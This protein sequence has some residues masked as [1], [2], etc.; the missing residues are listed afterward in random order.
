MKYVSG[1][2]L[3]FFFL[4]LFP[5]GC[6]DRQMHGLLNDIETYIQEKPD[7]ALIVL[8]SVDKAELNT[9]SLRAHFALLYAMALDK[10]WIDTTDLDVVMPAIAYYNDHPSGD[11]R[12]KAWYYLGRIQ[13]NRGQN[14]EASISFLKAEIF[15]EPSKDYSLKALIYQA[16][17]NMYNKT[18]Y[19]EEAL[20][21]TELAYS[22]ALKAGDS[23]K[24]D[25]ARY[26][27][28]QDLHNVGRHV[29][30]DSLYQQLINENR[31]HRNLRAS[32]LCN[33]ALNQVTRNENYEQAC[34]L[35][36]E[37]ISSTGSLR[38]ENFWGAYAY[39]LTRQG[40]TVRAETIFQQLGAVK[41]NSS[42]M[43]VYDYWKGQAAA[44]LGD[45]R[46]AYPLQKAAAD[47]QN[48]NVKKL[49][50]QSAMKA[51]KD[52]LEQEYRESEKSA[53]KKQLLA[54]CSVGIILMILILLWVLYKRQK[55][56]SAKE[57]ESLME[58][59]KGLTLQH[60]ILSSQYLD[61]NAQV[62]R[63]EQEKVSVR[64]K[65]IQMCQS[66]FSRLGRINE[67][68]YYHSKESDSKLYH[69]IKRAIQNI[70]MDNKNQIEFEKLLNETFDEVMAHFRETFPNKKPRYY[71]LVSF[72]FAGFDSSTI[73]SIIPGFQKHNVHVEK[74]R[75][76]QTVRNTESPYRQQFL[77]L[78]S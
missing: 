2:H 64:N 14:P 58:A 71:Q 17:S 35:F 50:K 78:L 18:Y 19:N 22:F 69:E 68:L 52:Y 34:S 67:V 8:S 13:E 60:A 1:L 27:M 12:A 25:A 21:Y 44:Y 65:Y 10:N 48:D 57:K 47:I 53:K 30:S 23:L 75:L 49:L 38:N 32:L 9:K 42:Q 16:I 45:Y 39:A 72:L 3:F 29:E 74:F 31:L 24:I 5:V 33:Y 63:I 28:A 59:Y 43:Y 54:W 15:A 20:R 40:N 61:L 46:A 56:N 41:M 7:S 11:R 36:E 6:S 51:Q 77:R 4:I 62:D 66:H 37:V 73:C 26:R 55:E 70:G 76:K